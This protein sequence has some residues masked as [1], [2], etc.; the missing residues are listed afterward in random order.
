M[1]A[2]AHPSTSHIRSFRTGN[3]NELNDNRHA[4]LLGVDTR[5]N[6]STAENAAELPFIVLCSL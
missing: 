4:G 2:P 3:G 6:I 1:L 5:S